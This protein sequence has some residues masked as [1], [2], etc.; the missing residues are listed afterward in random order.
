[1]YIILCI[2]VCMYVYVCMFVC[3]YACLYVCV[4]V[5]YVY[6]VIMY[7]CMYVCM[8]VYVN[9]VCMCVCIFVC[10]YVYIY[11]CVYVCMYICMCVCV[12]TLCIMYN[13]VF[14]SKTKKGGMTQHHQYAVRNLNCHDFIHSNAESPQNDEEL[15]PCVERVQ[16]RFFPTQVCLCQMQH[17]YPRFSEKSAYLDDV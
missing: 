7:V 6:N 11:V 8:R 10:I 17:S 15:A 14:I 1:M 16:S 5:H 3:V 12:C 9:Y 4:Y 13:N 2:F